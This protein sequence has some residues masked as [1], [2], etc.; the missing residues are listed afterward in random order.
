MPDDP[1]QTVKAGNNANPAVAAAIGA[2]VIVASGLAAQFE[3]YAPKI[4]KDPIGIPTYCYGETELLNH[5]PTHIY[6]KSECMDLLRKRMARDYAPKLL[7]CVPAFADPKHVN[8][9]GALL[10]A[11]YNAGWAGACKS[12]MAASFNAG[13][14]VQGC[15]GFEGWY[16]TGR[17]RKTGQRIMFQGLVRRRIAEKTTC[18]R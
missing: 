14:W 10:D 9:F 8:Q 5:D 3:G 18:L 11:S 7:S 6:A 4:Y 17:N 12:R 2:A 16:V 13:Q 15:K 1:K